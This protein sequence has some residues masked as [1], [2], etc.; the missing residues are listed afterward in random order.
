MDF[1]DDV[2]KQ[3]FTTD[4]GCTMTLVLITPDKIIC[5]NLGDSRTI[6]CQNNEAKALSKD[7]K[8]DLE[9]EKYRIEKFSGKEVKW[10]RVEGKLA[11]SRALGD[12]KFKVHWLEPHE[13]AITSLCDFTETPIDE[14]V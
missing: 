2:P 8:P 11:I 6:L 9:E 4:A 5:A 13:Q 14:S 12:S 7:H 3:F 10:G 1:D